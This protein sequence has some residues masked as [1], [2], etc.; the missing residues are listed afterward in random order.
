MLKREHYSES[1]TKC[2]KLQY[3]CNHITFFLHG[4]YCCINFVNIVLILQH[5]KR[6]FI[7]WNVGGLPME[8]HLQSHCFYI[9]FAKVNE[10][11]QK[12]YAFAIVKKHQYIIRC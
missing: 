6:M 10:L 5:K 2:Y 9:K 8:V 3:N 12:T 7:C 4:N 1:I 11:Q